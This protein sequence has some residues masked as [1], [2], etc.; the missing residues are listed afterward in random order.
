[1]GKFSISPR[2]GKLSADTLRL[3]SA[4]GVQ[5]A[6]SGHPGLPMG[7]ADCAFVLWIRFLKFNPKD[8]QWVNRDRFILSAGHGSM[9]LYSLLYLS[10][11]D[12]SLEDLK[13]FRQ[14]DSR[15]PGHPE[16]KC[17]PGVETTTGPLGQGFANGV[18]MAIAAK[19]TAERF[20][21]EEFS[22]FGTHCV[23][24]IVSDGDLMEGISSEAASIAGHLQ[25][26]NII[27]IYDDNNITIEGN[28]NTT[29]TESVPERFN[30]YGWQTIEVDGYDHDEIEE[31]IEKGIEEKDKPTLIIAKTHI[32]YGS[33][34]K[35]DTAG[36][37]GSP[38][39]EEELRETKRN[40]GFPEDKDF[41]VP[42]EVKEIFNSRIKELKEEYKCWQKQFGDWKEKNP[43]LWK[44]WKSF[45]EKSIPDNIEKELVGVLDYEPAATRSISGEV[46]QKIA[47]LVPG[48]CGGS[49]DLAPST[50]TFM[51]FFASIEPGQFEG[52]N[53]HFG[54]REHAMGGIINGI[55]V[56]NGFIPFGSTFLVFSDY[57]RPSIRLAAFM[58]L[59]VIYIF[60]HDSIFV[61][62]D[63]PTH[64]PVEQ[65]AALRTIPNLTVIRP[66]DGLEV[67]LSWS[68]AL[69][70]RKGPTA[71]VLSRQKVSPLKRSKNFD[72]SLI[73]KGGY[74]ISSEKNGSPDLVLI[75]SG[76]EVQVAMETQ[77][78]LEKEG[79]SI[80]VVS[81]PSLEI[82]KMQPE[83]FQASVIPKN[84]SR[85]VVIEAGVSQGWKDITNMPLLMVGIDH[86]GASAPY[87]VLAEKFG[88][89]AEKIVGKVR[90]WIREVN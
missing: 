42:D 22:V 26:G 68:N 35:H 9:L 30:A 56:Y 57:M 88:F 32:G 24:A 82:F 25:L 41:Y 77:K 20:N 15:T 16:Y 8:P 34:N 29:F 69:R 74:I 63:G 46:M 40:L 28:T 78:M 53:F 79:L 19:M 50:K 60:T 31:A 48:F 12:V 11:Y 45:A 85:V 6:N 52:R 66:A 83:S 76:S 51:K 17:L 70:N 67:A 47:E 33:P 58:G 87:K 23:Y 44:Q 62:E 18:G 13:S 39:G 2:L 1:M 54:I 75:A 90:E 65:L 4:D 43:D 64:Q 3:L 59:Q 73:F 7:M 86:F 71:L 55:A 72:S 49:A 14:W 81:M 10:G 5:K 27:Y 84:S 80:R 38:L 61:G 36:V 37:H 89:T 21:T